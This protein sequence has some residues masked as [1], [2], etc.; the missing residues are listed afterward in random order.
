MALEALCGLP[1]RRKNP[2]PFGPGDGFQDDAK[3]VFNAFARAADPMAIMEPPF[4]SLCRFL[5][6]ETTKFLN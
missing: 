4:V 3:D 5:K 6:I 2:N 1:P